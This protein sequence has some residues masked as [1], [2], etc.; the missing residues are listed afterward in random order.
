MITQTDR[1]D[2]PAADLI[3]H[4]DAVLVSALRALGD[5]YGPL[6]VALTAAALTDPEVLDARMVTA[7][8]L[9][10]E[11]HPETNALDGATEPGPDNAYPSTHLGPDAAC[12]STQEGAV[13]E[14]ICEW[15]KGPVQVMCQKGTGVC[16][17][18]C[19]RL[20][21]NILFDDPEKAAKFRRG[22]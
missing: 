22:E 20:A 12:D 9:P 13:M 3:A 2:Q 4:T 14:E 8:L 17:Q 15:C 19:A 11:N 1:G 10:S 7:G 6:G 21:S 18:Q 5:Q 16:S